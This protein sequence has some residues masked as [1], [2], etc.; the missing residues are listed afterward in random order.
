MN[1]RMFML[2]IAIALVMLGFLTLRFSSSACPELN[3]LD[4]FENNKTTVCERTK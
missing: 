4:D 3:T 1:N 2:L